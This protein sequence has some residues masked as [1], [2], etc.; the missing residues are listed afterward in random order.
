MEAL[1]RSPLLRSKVLN[2]WSRTEYLLALLVTV[3]IFFTWLIAQV[4]D[5]PE[6]FQG[7]LYAPVSGLVVF[8]ILFTYTILRI[9]WIVVWLHPTHLIRTIIKDFRTY[10][11]NLERLRQAFPLGLL[12]TIFFGAFSGMKSIIPIVNPYSWDQ[13]FATIDKRLH[14]GIHPWYL[15]HPILGYPVVTTTLNFFYNFWLLLLI[16]IFFWQALTFHLP[17]VRLQFLLTFFL[18]WIVVGHLLATLFSSAGPCYYEAVTGIVQGNP[19]AELMTYLRQ[20]NEQYPIWSVSTQEMLWHMYQE[21]K[22]RMGSGISAMPSM[23]VTI[24]FL[25]ALLGWKWGK[26]YNFLLAVYCVLIIL[27]SVHLAWHYAV[28]AY[29]TIPVTYGL[30]CLSGF[31]VRRLEPPEVRDFS[32]PQA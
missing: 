10:L 1:V 30:W 31:V 25:F 22:L 3:Y 18:S 19:Y 26:P 6:A 23:H 28:D 15:L 2:S 11:F 24:A 16:F 14:A 32:S 27:G 8:T 7:L 29:F 13:T 20:A 9:L 12:F 17:R 21:E 4:Y 5:R